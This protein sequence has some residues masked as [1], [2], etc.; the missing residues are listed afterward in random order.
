L[1]PEWSSRLLRSMRFLAW[2]SFGKFYADT[3]LFLIYFQPSDDLPYWHRTRL[4]IMKVRSSA[5][6]WDPSNLKNGRFGNLCLRYFL[7]AK[8]GRNP[9]SSKKPPVN[10]DGRPWGRSSGSVLDFVEFPWGNSTTPKASPIWPKK[11]C[12]NRIETGQIRR[13]DV[14]VRSYVTW[15]W[16]R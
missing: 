16:R 6:V 10:A 15:K 9:G 2:I 1:A 3:R 13:C 7:N 12:E 4:E 5:C 11:L 14:R 8:G